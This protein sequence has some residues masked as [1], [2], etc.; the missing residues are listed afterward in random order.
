MGN[1]LT[2]DEIKET[3]RIAGIFC[4]VSVKKSLPT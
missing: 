2:T 1:E 4:R 3:A